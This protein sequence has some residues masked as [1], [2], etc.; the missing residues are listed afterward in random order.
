MSGPFVH[1]QSV[2]CRGLDGEVQPGAAKVELEL[3]ISP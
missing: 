1:T 2:A 3:E